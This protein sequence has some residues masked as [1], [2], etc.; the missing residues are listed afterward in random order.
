MT[1]QSKRTKTSIKIAPYIL[2]WF[3][4]TLVHISI[5]VIQKAYPFGSR[6]FLTYDA[7]T[8]YKNMFHMLFTW[9]SG[10]QHG[11]FLWNMGM[12][13][14]AYQEALYYCLSPFNVI[15]L[16]MGEKRL[17]L[18]IVIL[19][20]VKSACIPVTALYFF[21]H[22]NRNR[23]DNGYPA[24]LISFIQ[25]TC[26]LAYGLCGYVLAYGH[27][28]MWLDGLIMLPLIAVSIERLSSGKRIWQYVALL[29]ITIVCN[30]Y[31]AFYI[32]IFALI[33]F[34]LENRASWREFWKKSVIFAVASLIAAM[35]SG[36]VL[37]PAAYVVMNAVPSVRSIS[38]PGTIQWGQIGEYISSFYSLKEIRCVELFSNNSFCGSLAI[39]LLMLFMT[40][41]AVDIKTRVK[42]IIAIGVLVL[43][44]NYLPLNYAFHGF[45]M[46]HGL[47]NR[48]AFILTFLL[49]TAAYMVIM[50]MDSLKTKNVVIS[51]IITIAIFVV[52]ILDN[53][54]MS[55][56]LG[57]V[58]FLMSSVLVVVMLIF[59]RRNSVKLV[60]VITMMCVIWCAEL[61]GNA[62]FTMADKYEDELLADSIQ[63]DKWADDYDELQVDD[64]ERKTAMISENYAPYTQTNWYSSMANGDVIRA[65]ASIGL[66]HFDNVEYLYEGTTP[67]TTLM[68]NVR[69]VLSQDSG[70]YSGY[71]VEKS[72]DACNVYRA[73]ELAGM[74]FVLD[75]DI[76]DWQA[77]DVALANQNDFIRKGCGVEADA[78]TELDMSDWTVSY[79]NQDVLAEDVGY[80]RY[81][82]TNVFVPMMKYEFDAES[83][84]D[85]Y[86][87]SKDVRNHYIEVVVD[88]SEVVSNASYSTEM[89]SHIGEV[90]KGQHVKITVG[91]ETS[92]KTGNVGEKWLKVYSFNSE[93]FDDAK[94]VIQENTLNECRIENGYFTGKVNTDKD[95]ILYIAYPY[96]DG[97][98]IYMDGEKV[99]K[100]RLGTGNMGVKISKGSHSIEIRYRTPGL[101]WGVLVSIIGIILFAILI[102]LDISSV[103]DGNNA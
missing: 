93:V 85:L 23:I 37:V 13:I 20:I 48:F 43:A 41:K 55:T 102:R 40:S 28:I 18:S 81:R 33:Y 11:T 24:W 87:Y 14:D 54:D 100:L 50:N 73:D 39:L 49:V 46:T 19:L 38:I 36:V 84:I 25:I 91:S 64:A 94:S 6:S 66:S 26:S 97:F 82:T 53:R 68:Y 62:L 58:I 72:N 3:V 52:S 9:L 12:G 51:I 31:F 32:C 88:G 79:Y 67:L 44:L 70:M 35:L 22:T 4:I 7:Y 1:R 16:A 47:G 95:G 45:T 77:E 71:S 90:S 65:F 42:F 29:A 89:V 8:Q 98:T 63:L 75:D 80:C 96:N 59:W 101:H 2:L 30:F 27:N 78:F 21:R 103:H 92:F 15:V 5:I 60:T 83:D 61:F 17:E 57:Y 10:K 76:A 34:I 74:G 99:D 69:Y 86:V 56:P